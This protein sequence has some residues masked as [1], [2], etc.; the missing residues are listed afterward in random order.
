MML[1]TNEL[2]SRVKDGNVKLNTD[3]L[4]ALEVAADSAEWDSQ[5]ERIAGHRR[6]LAVYA[7]RSCSRASLS[8]FIQPMTLTGE[9]VL[10][11]AF[12]LGMPEAQLALQRR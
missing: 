5:M 1:N 7:K 2:Q 12:L 8:V 4:K 9:N 3:W 10:K 6:R 11:R